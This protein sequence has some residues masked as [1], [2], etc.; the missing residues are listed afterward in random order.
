MTT[1]SVVV[2]SRNDARFLR[3]CLQDLTAQTRRPDEIVVVDND[4]EDETAQVGRDAGAR[5]VLQ[6]QIGI[7]P[8]VSA[9]YDAASGDI[10]FRLDADSRPPVDWI[11]H[12]LAVFEAEPGLDML[13]GHGD[14]YGPRRIIN[15][16]G[17]KLYIGGMYA[18]LTPYFGHAPIFGSNFAMRREVWAQMRTT[19]HVD[20]PGIHD[21]MDLTYQVRPWMTISYDPGWRVGI[22]ARP[23]DTFSSLGRRLGWVGTTVKANWPES[24]PF[25]HRRARKR[26]Q[27]LPSLAQQR[28][29]HARSAELRELDGEPGHPGSTQARLP[30]STPAGRPASTPPGQAD[31]G[32]S[33]SGQAEA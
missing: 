13:V 23:F 16:I 11:E 26:W 14:F 29:L 7:W 5:V 32:R 9:G 21:D 22:S 19:A 28:A 12:A 31:S 17:T 4:S 2:P 8:A 3:R 33:G 18:V 15:W 30:G 10:I 27:R 20:H 25:V 24:R 6:K 1:V